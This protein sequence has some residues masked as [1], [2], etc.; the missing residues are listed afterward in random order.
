MKITK[1]EYTKQMNDLTTRKAAVEAMVAKIIDTEWTEKYPKLNAMHDR[2]W[3]LEQ[4]IKDLESRWDTR[5]WTAGDWASH[6]LVAQN[7]D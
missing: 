1:R 5:N 6:S 3:K 7:I 4:A 2:V